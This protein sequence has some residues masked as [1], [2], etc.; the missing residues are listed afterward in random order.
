[1]FGKKNKIECMICGANIENKKN[2]HIQ[3]LK[4]DGHIGLYFLHRECDNKI[5]K[6]KNGGKH[7][8]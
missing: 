1:M 7:E 4:V 5:Q 2:A 6:M 3:Y 8:R